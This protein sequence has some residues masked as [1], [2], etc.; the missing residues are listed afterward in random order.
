MKPK[1]FTLIELL[2]AVVVIGVLAG[3][4]L[5][6]LNADRI[7]GT[8]RDA[9][10]AS[11][12]GRIQAALELYYAQNR[13]YPVSPNSGGSGTWSNVSTGGNGDLD[14]VLEAGFLSKFPLDPIDD[15]TGD[16]NGPC[17]CDNQD[18]NG[19]CTDSFRYNYISDGTYY[20]LT[21]IMEVPESADP[22]L[23][24]TFSAISSY[25]GSPTASKNCYAV[26]NP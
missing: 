23:C 16:H 17:N 14:T 5:S 26:Q 21:A 12:L 10:R 9:Q 22:S 25:C 15:D 20:L 3:I 13:S 4:L 2:I 11:D 18:A 7:R 24:S 1:G 6:V 19:S 8:A